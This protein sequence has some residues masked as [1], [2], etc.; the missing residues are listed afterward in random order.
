[1]QYPD[2]SRLIAMGKYSMHSKE[3]R[4][5]V[6]RVQTI[7]KTIMHLA[8]PVLDDCQERPPVDESPLKKLQDCLRNVED[9]RVKII[10]H[11]KAMADL[12]TEA[13]PK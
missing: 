13:W 8:N 12:E 5:Q 6:E 3:R 2:E 10:E 4:A 7:C 9:A 1:M 11:C